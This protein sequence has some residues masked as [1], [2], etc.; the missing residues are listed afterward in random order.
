M[1]ADVPRPPLMTATARGG[2]E[3]IAGCDPSRARTDACSE[4]LDVPHLSARRGIEQTTHTHKT[5]K[6]CETS[7]QDRLRGTPASSAPLITAG[8]F[9]PG[10]SDV[11]SRKGDTVAWAV[12]DHARTCRWASCFVPAAAERSIVCIRMGAAS[13][14][15]QHAM[16]RVDPT[17]TRFSDHSRMALLS[18][19]FD[20]RWKAHVRYCCSL[21]LRSRS[22][23]AQLMDFAHRETASIEFVA[24]RRCTSFDMVWMWEVISS[25]LAPPSNTNPGRGRKGAR[26]RS[27][28]RGVCMASSLRATA[29]QA[30]C[31]VVT[32]LSVG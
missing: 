6:G 2:G 4:I 28:L 26:I 3:L 24:R 22:G 23:V 17:R 31:G 5:S 14:Q 19:R 18:T 25:C 29:I 1:S 21:C 8:H 30:D 11:S 15:Q 12:E 10:S 7:F 20:E 9:V 27:L 13:C 16:S 32:I